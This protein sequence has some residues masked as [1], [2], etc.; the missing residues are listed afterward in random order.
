MSPSSS[1]FTL[2]R[3]HHRH[4]HRYCIDVRIGVG[5]DVASTSGSLSKLNRC[6]HRCRYRCR[7]RYRYRCSIDVGTGIDAASM[8]ASVSVSTL[9]RCRG[10]VRYPCC[11]DIGI[12]VS[13]TQLCFETHVVLYTYMPCVSCVSVMPTCTCCMLKY[14][15]FKIFVIMICKTSPLRWNRTTGPPSPY[16]FEVRTQHQSR[17]ARHICLWWRA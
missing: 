3:C 2:H 12:D 17:S 5:V 9:H 4:R 14:L 7:Y 1:V 8:S 11:I 13:Y 16:G 15:W 6:Q 10:R